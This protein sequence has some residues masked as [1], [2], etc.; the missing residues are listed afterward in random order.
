MPKTIDAG[1]RLAGNNLH[2]IIEAHQSSVAAGNIEPGNRGEIGSVAFRKPQL[3]VVIVIH[4]GIA[5]AR[6]PFIAAH[7][8]A[9]CGGNVFGLH[10]HAG[11][12]STVNFNA[13]LRFIQAQG[14]IRIN[15]PQFIGAKAQTFRKFTEGLQVRAEQREINLPTTAAKPE[16]LLIAHP[17]TKFRVSF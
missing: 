2:K 15:K 4:F 1:G 16:G 6:D 17:A 10:T 3:D 9:Q 11:G 14:C 7:H 12:S 8:D 13:Q 5:I